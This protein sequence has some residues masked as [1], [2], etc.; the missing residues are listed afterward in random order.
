MNYPMNHTGI[1]AIMIAN[2]A[3]DLIG[4]FFFKFSESGQ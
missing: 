3:D 4:V 2:D 1:S